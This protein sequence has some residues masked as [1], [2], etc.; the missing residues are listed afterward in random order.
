MATE[1]TNNVEP[2]LRL[3]KPAT[4][5]HLR[6]K[7]PIRA[8]IDIILNDHALEDYEEAKKSYE[9]SLLNKRVSEEDRAALKEALECAKVELEEA[10]VTM[11]FQAIG[12][13]AYERLMNDH[14][15]TEE[16]KIENEDV[17]YNPDT[18]PPAL[19]AASCI[20]PKMEEED[21]KEICDT[22]NGAEVTLLF[23]TALQVNTATR[24]VDGASRWPAG[25][26]PGQ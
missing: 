25:L 26:S 2:A 24:T 15:A 1:P 13:G 14:P 19:I 7:E 23:Y 6:K 3:K 10:T 22:W 9:L 20:E 18:F 16:Q 17:P 8:S 5:D 12:R 21:A 4:L 11:T